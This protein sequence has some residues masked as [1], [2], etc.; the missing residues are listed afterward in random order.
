MRLLARLASPVLAL[1]LGA[2]G[3]SAPPSAM[4]DGLANAS[5][6]KDGGDEAVGIVE[7]NGNFAYHLTSEGLRVYDVSD[8]NR[9]R[10]LGQH[11][12]VGWPL[13]V[14][15][16]GSVATILMR[17]HDVSV[18]AASVQGPALVRAIDVRD[19]A[20]LT[21]LSESAIEGDVQEARAT[22]ESVYVLSE[23]RSRRSG[24]VV[25]TSVRLD[26]SKASAAHSARR[27]GTAGTLRWVAGRIVLAYA[28]LSRP[29]THVDVLVDSAEAGLVQRGTVDLRATLDQGDQGASPRVDAPDAAHVHVVGCEANPCAAGDLLE[30]VTLDVTDPGRPHVRSVRRVPSPGASLTTRFDGERLYLSPRGRL[31]LGSPS[32]TVSVMDLDA[33]TELWRRDQSLKGVVWNL[34]PVGSHLIVVATRGDADAT[35]EQVVLAAIDV[36]DGQPRAPISEVVLGGE[37]SSSTAEANSQAVVA[38]A[39]T[40]AVPFRTWEGRP[41]KIVSRIALVGGTARGLS[42]SGEVSVEGN[43]EQLVCV[44]DHLLVFTDLGL[45]SMDL[46]RARPERVSIVESSAPSLFVPG[47]PS[48][49]TFTALPMSRQVSGSGEACP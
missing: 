33:S 47:Y 24:Q 32:T 13:G 28:D 10:L 38:C 40:L 36:R 46:G 27:E 17:W 11:P 5:A 48:S 23:L 7:V 35:R 22:A 41:L 25:V 29:R 43:V 30:V 4:A 14:V 26:G 45:R 6:R 9:P 42:S 39:G 20:H 2:T 8:P 16:R 18:C 31:S 37:W 3:L 44:A 34:L 1:V 19:P 12:I 15:V 49:P 21:V